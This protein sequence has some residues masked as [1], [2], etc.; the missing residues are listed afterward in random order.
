MR[1]ALALAFAAVAATF[2]IG[3]AP[4]A[5]AEDQGNFIKSLQSHGIDV[6]DQAAAIRT[7]WIVRGMA[8]L[9]PTV[10]DEQPESARFEV[11]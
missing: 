4:P 10:A 3:G 1:L 7:P 11:S 2:S 6:S 8:R 5:H 9:R